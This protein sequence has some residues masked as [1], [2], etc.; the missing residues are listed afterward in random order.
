MDKLGKSVCIGVIFGIIFYFIISSCVIYIVILKNKGMVGPSRVL[1]VPDNKP[2]QMDTVNSLQTPI[3]VSP[4]PDP[5][6]NCEVSINDSS[7]TFEEI[8][9]ESTIQDEKRK[10]QIHSCILSLKTNIILTLT[11]FLLIFTAFVMPSLLSGIFI[12]TLKTFA[13]CLTAIS[14]FTKIQDELVK[15]RNSFLSMFKG[16][17]DVSS[18]SEK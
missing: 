18:W 7:T 15:L 9:N 4:N 5:E 14:N 12:L 10:A 17:Q 16:T 8:F 2:I 11:G 1:V 3:E 13:P 6:R